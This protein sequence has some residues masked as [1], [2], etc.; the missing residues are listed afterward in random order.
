MIDN[1]NIFNLT[2]FI[3]FFDVDTG[4]TM[5][6]FVDTTYFL[7]H[8]ESTSA[9][10]ESIFRCLKQVIEYMDL[11]LKNLVGLRSDGASVLT[12]KENEVTAKFKIFPQC[13]NLLS[14][15]LKP[16]ILKPL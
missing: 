5:T 13:K 4:K 9:D 10:L 3:R 7:E 14:K 16:K 8:S 6:R 15:I 1:L 2:M 11:D 12:G